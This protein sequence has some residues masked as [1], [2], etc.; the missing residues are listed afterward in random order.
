MGISAWEWD[1]R[2]LDRRG[3]GRRGGRF[4]WRSDKEGH[5]RGREKRL[6]GRGKIWFI[7]VLL[8]FK[9]ETGIVM[10]TRTYLFG[11]GWWRRDVWD[12]GPGD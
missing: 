6:D 12:I 1:V 9:I 4:G 10:S 8:L 11:M 3:T 2:G 7:D 5:G